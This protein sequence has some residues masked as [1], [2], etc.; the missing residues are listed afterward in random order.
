MKT[1]N[2]TMLKTKFELILDS[3]NF[4]WLDNIMCVNSRK[5]KLWLIYKHYIYYNL[6]FENL[7]IYKYF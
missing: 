3:Q 7:N 6:A 1:I 2:I 4:N 5:I